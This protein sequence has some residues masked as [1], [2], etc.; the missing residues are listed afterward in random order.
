MAPLAWVRRIATELPE[1][2]AI[3]LF[4]NSPPFDWAHFSKA[5][6]Q[7]LGCSELSITPRAMGWRDASDLAQGIGTERLALPI[8]LAPLGSVHWIASRQDIEKLTSWMIKPNG[9]SLKLSS[10]ILQEGFYRFLILQGLQ[11][12]QPMPPFENFTLQLSEDEEPFSRSFCIDIEIRYGANK[13]WSRLVIPA[14]FRAAWI[15]YFSQMPSEY[16]SAEIA[17][18]TQLVLGVKTG[19]F[20]LSQNEWNDLQTGDFIPLDKESYNP[21]KQTGIALLMLK[22]TPVFNVKIHPNRME[23]SD[24]AFYYED[25]MEQKPTRPPKRAEKLPSE[26]GEAVALKE[27]PLYVTVE[28]ARLKIT[29]DQLMHLTPGNVLELPVHPEQGV[30]LTIQGQKVGRAE[31]V[32]L[33][34]QLGV[35]ILE[36]G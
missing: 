17:R 12:I 33:G 6:A 19:S 10:E 36:I 8:S 4:G 23:F 3:P 11:L 24:Y 28:I 20:V 16:F 29:L 7:Q 2:E 1:L 13:C 25:N 18:Q 15:Q 21:R 5:F 14:E 30:S 31:L 26:E 9:K 34:E 27:L 35:R 32:Y 22:S